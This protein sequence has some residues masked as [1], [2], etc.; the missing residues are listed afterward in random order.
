MAAKG[1]ID[2]RTGFPVGSVC[3]FDLDGYRH[4]GHFHVSMWADWDP[5]S[6]MIYFGGDWQDVEPMPH[7]SPDITEEAVAAWARQHGGPADL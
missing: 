7:P 5:A 1:A 3:V 2:D 6:R 4:P